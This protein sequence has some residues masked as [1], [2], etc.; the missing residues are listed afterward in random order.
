MGVT[1]YWRYSRENMQEL[2][3]QGRIVQAKPGTV[4]R[5]KRYLD[6]MSGVPIQ[7]LWT[8]VKPIGA[9]A[10]ERLG[11]PTQKP[12]SL[13]ERIIEASSNAGDVVCDPFCGCGAAVAVAHR[14]DRQW[15]GIDITHL[16]IGLI[17]QRLRDA[18]GNEVN[19]AYEVIGE[20][21]S[22]AGA[23]ELAASDPYQFQWWSLGLVGARPAEE[24]KGADL[25]ID[26]R[27]YFHDDIQR[28]KTKQ[29]IFSVKAGKTSSPH[30]R[31]LRGV[32][33]REGAAIGVLLTMQKPTRPMMK[34]AASAGFYESPGWD[35]KHPRLQILT[36]EELLNGKTIDMPPLA[37]RTD[38]TFRKAPEAKPTKEH[39]ELGL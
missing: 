22:V 37:R 17:K 33:D 23:A 20:P 1:R 14:L 24:K 28:G 32:I 7:D 15:I 35:R 21:E 2:I 27:L 10:A 5:Y 19:A 25:G 34:E 6:E 38:A 36:V 13:L 12:E 4:P 3:D 31:D 26:G 18:F 39:P 29:V 8:D 30:V 16:A 11:Y 9:Q